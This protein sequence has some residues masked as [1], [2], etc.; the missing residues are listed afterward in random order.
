MAT[1]TD[2]SDLLNWITE[3]RNIGQEGEVIGRLINEIESADAEI[4]RLRELTD[5]KPMSS[6]PMDGTAILATSPIGPVLV[7]WDSVYE[8]WVDGS[9]CGQKVDRWMPIGPGRPL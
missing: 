7:S 2:R 5:W 6:A 9:G 1:H 4:R 3:R 8:E